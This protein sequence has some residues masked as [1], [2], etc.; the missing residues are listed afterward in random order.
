MTEQTVADP[1]VSNALGLSPR[2][3]ANVSGRE[4]GPALT[5]EGLATVRVCR[6]CGN[7]GRIALF[8]A[9]CSDLR[10][11]DPDH[12]RRQ[13]QREQSGQ[14]LPVHAGPLG[15][16]AGRIPHHQLRFSIPSCSPS[17]CR[18]HWRFRAVVAWYLAR[19]DIFGKR[20]IS[21]RCGWRSFCRSCLPR[22]DGFCCLDPNYGIIH[23]KFVSWPD[24]LAG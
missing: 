8:G 15:A 23:N 21:M 13:L 18:L 11:A 16:G 12:R 9:H 20:T 17:G 2:R 6:P 22:S 4:T 10:G 7:R 3:S 19:N 14:C 5:F 1:R 24:R